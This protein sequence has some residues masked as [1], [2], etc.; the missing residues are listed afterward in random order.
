M[1]LVSLDYIV[2][3]VL[4]SLEESSMRRYQ[5]YLQ[6]CI[7]G[8]REFNINN[9]STPKVIHRQM[10]PDKSINIPPDYVKYVLIG[11]CHE[12]RIITLGRDESMC[13]NDNFND[14]GDPIEVVIPKLNDGSYSFLA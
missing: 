14:C 9:A 7:R 8:F 11:L 3:N 2:R 5:T 1:K 10:L 12:G 4:V 13:L 6:Y